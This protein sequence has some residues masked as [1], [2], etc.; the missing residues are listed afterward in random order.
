[1]TCTK[2]MYKQIEKRCLTNFHLGF[3]ATL[4]NG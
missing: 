4:N 2:G 3:D 1:M